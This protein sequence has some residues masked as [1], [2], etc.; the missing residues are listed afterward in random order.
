MQRLQLKKLLNKIKWLVF[1]GSRRETF[2]E[3]NKE[4]SS[5]FYRDPVS[6]RLRNGCVISVSTMRGGVQLFVAGERYYLRHDRF[7]DS[8]FLQ[9]E[10]L[11]SKDW[12]NLQLWDYNARPAL[13]VLKSLISHNPFVP[14]NE[15]VRHVG[16]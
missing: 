10:V 5:L 8:I 14:S 13:K 7:N 16:Y 3:L 6:Y 15:G 2:V 1:T 12:E 9:R 11:E 4:L